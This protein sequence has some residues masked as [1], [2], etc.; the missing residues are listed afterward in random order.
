MARQSRESVISELD[1][2]KIG[3]DEKMN[4]MEL[5][6]ILNEAKAKKKAEEP[7]NIDYAGVRCGQS[8]INNLHARI[9]IIERK[10]GL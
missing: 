8:T 9:C 1:A 7:L 3:Y 10:L 4:Y 5:L 6:D 2:R